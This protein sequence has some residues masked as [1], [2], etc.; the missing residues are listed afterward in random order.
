MS[1]DKV[2]DVKVLKT[3]AKWFGVTYKE[4]TPMVNAALAA[5][6]KEGKYLDL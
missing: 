4:D 3:D 1:K 2:A 6:D 5:F